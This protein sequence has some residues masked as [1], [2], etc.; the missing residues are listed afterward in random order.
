MLH[1]SSLAS[2]PVWFLDRPIY[3]GYDLRFTPVETKVS[4]PAEATFVAVA[5]LTKEPDPSTRACLILS[6]SRSRYLRCSLW[7]VE[8]SRVAFWSRRS[9]GSC[10]HAPSTCLWGLR[11]GGFVV[12]HLHTRTGGRLCNIAWHRTKSKIREVRIWEMLYADDA[13]LVSPTLLQLGGSTVPC[14]QGVR[15]DHQ[16]KHYN[17]HDSCGLHSFHCRRQSDLSSG[18]NLQLP[19]IHEHNCNCHQTDWYAITN[20]IVVPRNPVASL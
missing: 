15:T 4:T 1:V 6:T 19:W 9:S 16:S 11:W 8:W 14:L 12:V 20:L 13:A 5:D 10:L 3:S 17:H 7:T 18:R 2:T